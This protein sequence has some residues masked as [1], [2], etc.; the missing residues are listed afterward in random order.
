MYDT[1]TANLI[2]STPP[3]HDLDREAL[4]DVLT[5]AYAEIA[6]LRVRLR[7]DDDPPDDLADTR[8]F[9]HKLAQTNEGLVALSP[10]R[11]DRR[12]AAFVAVTAYQ[13]VHQIDVVSG[14]ARPPTQL[15]SAYI[16]ADVSAMLLFLVRSLRPTPRKCHSA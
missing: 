9:A 16:T 1:N 8:A 11:K 12:A 10:N 7:A 2:R 3:L 15:T 6:A 4:P 5:A 14:T 13:L